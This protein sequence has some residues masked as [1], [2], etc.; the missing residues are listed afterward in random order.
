MPE[1]ENAM[2]ELK[3]LDKKDIAEMKSF[4]SPPD[5]VR[6]V[7]DAVSILLGKPQKWSD[8]KVLLGSMDFLD[9]LSNFNK[10][11]IPDGTIRKLRQYMK[12]PEFKPDIVGKKA[13]AAKS[14]CMWCRAMFKYNEVIKI[15]NPKRENVRVI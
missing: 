2:E 13:F 12:N 5:A 9:T 11:N 7:M 15:V 6:M 10:D 1:L 3:A 8:Q 14:L 4:P